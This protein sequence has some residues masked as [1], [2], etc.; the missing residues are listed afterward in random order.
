MNV[1]VKLL[2]FSIV[3]GMIYPVYYLWETDRIKSVCQQI[4]PGLSYDDIVLNLQQSGLK[5]KQMR[6]DYTQGEKW[7]ALIESHAS[8]RGYGCE[9]RGV[10]KQIAG[11]RIVKGQQIAP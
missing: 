4:E 10:G 8:F 5:L 9:V 3:L 2:Q 1:L 11:S 7:Q 6:G